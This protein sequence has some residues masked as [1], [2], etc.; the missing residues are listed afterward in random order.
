MGVSALAAVIIVLALGVTVALVIRAKKKRDAVYTRQ[1]P[2]GYPQQPGYPGYPQQS[3]YPGYPPQQAYPQQPGYP[4]APPQQQSYPP[5]GQYPP[6][7]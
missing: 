3:G 4:Q 7:Q 5:P 6:H 2:V 1:L